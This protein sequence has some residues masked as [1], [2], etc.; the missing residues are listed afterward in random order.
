MLTERVTLYIPV[1]NAARYLHEV[2]PAVMAQTYPLAEVLVVDDGS[3]DDSAH[4]VEQAT[5]TARYPMRLIRHDRNRGLGAARNTAIEHTTTP[6]I[7]AIDSDVVLE[8]D[9]LATLLPLLREP[10]IAGAGGRLIERYVIGPGDVWRDTFMRQSHGDVAREVGGLFGSNTVFWTD[11]LRSVE[12]YDPRCR[13]N[14]EDAIMA[15]R[16][17]AIGL[18]FRYTPDARC[19][20]LRQDTVPSI[21]NTFWRWLYFSKQDEKLVVSKVLRSS[22]QNFR[23]LFWTMSRSIRAGKLSC[24]WIALLLPFYRSCKDWQCYVVARKKGGSV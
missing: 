7:A 5:A 1:Y 19:W 4:I 2:L 12:G 10:G 18:R 23:D 9:W 21:M 8:P 11:M 24:V 15:E 22:V 6:I 16:L 13:T 3:V 17:K 14:G 20:H